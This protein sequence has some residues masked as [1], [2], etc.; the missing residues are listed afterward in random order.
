MFSVEFG[1]IYRIFLISSV[2]ELFGNSSW[3]NF[4]R[5]EC[6]DAETDIYV[7]EYC[8][9][10][11]NIVQFFFKRPFFNH[12]WS[13]ENLKKIDKIKLKMKERRT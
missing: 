3:I 5:V 11:L 1:K 10:H 4:F 2:S 6:L 7:C 9:Y 8:K 13:T 12:F